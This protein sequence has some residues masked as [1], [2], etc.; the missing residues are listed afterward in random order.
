MLTRPRAFVVTAAAPFIFYCRIS[1]G[2]FRPRDT[3]F[4]LGRSLGP[5]CFPVR[6]WPCLWDVVT[7]LGPWCF[8]ANCLIY[9]LEG[10]RISEGTVPAPGKR[11]LDSV[12]PLGGARCFPVRQGRVSLVS[13]YSNMLQPAEPRFFDHLSL[14]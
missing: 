6:Q 4:G 11:I 9:L 12:R 1:E 5:W 13:S 2:T 3:Y 14:G 10:R 8:P 7:V